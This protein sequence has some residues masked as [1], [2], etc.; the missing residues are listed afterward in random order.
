MQL[1]C[2]T[3]ITVRKF[4]IM[5]VRLTFIPCLLNKREAIRIVCHA[6]YL[7]HTSRLFIKLRRLRVPDIVHSNTCIFMYAAFHNRLP[8]SIQIYF[9]RSIC[10]KYYFNFYVHFA[11]TQKKKISISRIAVSIGN[12]LDTKIF[13]HPLK[14]HYK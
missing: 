11:R 10:K 4:K 7:N 13:Y 3:L 6:K 1:L 9:S 8:P 12:A 2:L 14:L 5:L